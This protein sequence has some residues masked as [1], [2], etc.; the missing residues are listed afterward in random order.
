MKPNRLFLAIVTLLFCT[1]LKAQ[2][3]SLIGLYYKDNIDYL[4]DTTAKIS[5]TK[6]NE[7]RGYLIDYRFHFSG[8]EETC[9]NWLFF[10]PFKENILIG[11]IV[12]SETTTE[13]FLVPSV[14]EGIPAYTMPGGIVFHR[15]EIML[16]EKADNK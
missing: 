3:E 1:S 8:N 7:L 15:V 9:T 12:E 11:T 2:N 14:D 16:T 5:Y 10:I 4:F 6:T 13:P